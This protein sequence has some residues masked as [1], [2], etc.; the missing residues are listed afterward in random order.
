MYLNIYWETGWD[1]SPTCPPRWKSNY[2]QGREE[3]ASARVNTGYPNSNPRDDVVVTEAEASVR[4]VADA[5]VTTMA[6]T[7]T[8]RL[9]AGFMEWT[10]PASG[11]IYPA[12]NLIR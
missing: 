9:K 2:L 1:P 7:C 5:T 12:K 11:G 8:V 6:L 3:G 10:A 4:D